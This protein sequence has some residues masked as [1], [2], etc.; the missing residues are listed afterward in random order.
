MTPPLV[1]WGAGEH[2]LVVADI[3]RQRAEYRLI[4]WIDDVDTT[5][6][7]SLLS[8][9]PILGGREQ[10]DRLREQGVAHLALAVGRCEARLRLADVAR[11]AGFAL[12][13]L[14]HP[15]AIVGTDVAVGDGAVV[16]AGAIL[17]VAAEIGA[18]VMIAPAVV[19]H[20]VVL[21]DGVL[22]G[23]GCSLGGGARVGRGSLIGT[24]ATVAPHV[25][26]GRGSLIGA[27]AV[28]TRDI[29]DSVVA[30]GT[31]A[32]VIRAVTPADGP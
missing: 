2:A 25:R 13:A 24:G 32:R 5:R 9:L 11:A 3:V 29:P 12:P 23:G 15:R 14:A 7:G 19:S 16:R 8:G 31:P 30:Y 4:G 10:L 27:G 17:D 26:I 18:V 21:E 1:I 6:H 20:H 28:V 22:V